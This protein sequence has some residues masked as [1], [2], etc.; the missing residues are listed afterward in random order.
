M[1]MSG[2]STNECMESTTEIPESF[3]CGVSSI[4]LCRS[5]CALDEHLLKEK[6]TAAEL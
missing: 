2:T 1:L 4:I 6:W 3:T 5:V